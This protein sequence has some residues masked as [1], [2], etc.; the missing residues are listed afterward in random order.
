MSGAPEPSG[1]TPIVPKCGRNGTTTPSSA[2]SRATLPGGTIVPASSTRGRAPV[3]GEQRPAEHRLEIELVDRHPLLAEVLVQMTPVAGEVGAVRQP[4][5][6]IED[7]DL[8]HIARPGAGDRDRAGQEVRAGAAVLHLGEY[9]LDACVHQQI[10]C[11]AGVV[12]ERLDRYEVAALDGQDRL[13]RAVEVAPVHGLRCR[14]KMVK[15]H[16]TPCSTNARQPP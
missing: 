2:G 3:V 16:L 9:P 12:R 4:R 8:E 6:R 1:A 15:H 14:G 10:G 13:E 11:V 7:V 5:E